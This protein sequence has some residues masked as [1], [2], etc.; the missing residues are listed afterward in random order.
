MTGSH[1]TN[2]VIG[3]VVVALLIVAGL[4][5]FGVDSVKR[6]RRDDAGLRIFEDR[7]GTDEQFGQWN[8]ED[9]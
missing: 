8:R 6:Y 2:V 5:V 9:R 7:P 1:S 4:V 3:L